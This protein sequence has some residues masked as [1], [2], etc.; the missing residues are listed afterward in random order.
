MR[1]LEVLEHYHQNDLILESLVKFS[2]RT[3]SAAYCNDVALSELIGT[4]L[5]KEGIL[6]GVL[7]F[8]NSSVDFAWGVKFEEVFAWATNGNARGNNRRACPRVA[9]VIAAAAITPKPS[10]NFC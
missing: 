3:E 10:S 1:V 6:F 4:L 7:K 5:L 9:I 2:P 8:V